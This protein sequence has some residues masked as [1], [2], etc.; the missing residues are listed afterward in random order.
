M[1]TTSPSQPAGSGSVLDL[2]SQNLA[3]LSDVAAEAG[4]AAGDSIVE[5]VE[6]GSLF[7][8]NA[9]S[10]A[11]AYNGIRVPR[12]RVSAGRIERTADTIEAPVREYANTRLTNRAGHAP[13]VRLGLKDI[14]L[15]QLP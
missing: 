8:G 15:F 5:L 13:L 2:T 9:T 4:S 12:Y 14:L 7:T 1:S 3:M 6:Q 11:H 10:F